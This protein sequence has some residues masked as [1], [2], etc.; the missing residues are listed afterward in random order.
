MWLMEG[1][2]PDDKTICN[3]RKD[4][5]KP[6]KETFREFSRMCQELKLYGGE[7]IAQDSVK[8]RANNSL[9]NIHNGTTVKNALSRIDKRIGE[10]FKMLEEGDREEEGEEKPGR[11]QIRAALERLKERKDAYEE[12]KKQLEGESEVS[13]VD[14][15]ARLMRS[16][17]EGRKLDVCYNVQTV[18]D[19]KH[20]LVVDYEVTDCPNDTGSLKGMAGRAME[21]MGVKEVTV[22]ADAG[23]YSSEDIAACEGGGVTCLVP[24]PAAGGP[25][26]EEGFNRKDFHYDRER[27][28]YIC[29]CQKELKHKYNKKH[30]SG[31]EYRVYSN[32]SACRACQKK[33]KCT[34]YRN[35]EVLRLT[36]QDLL[37]IV[38]E[39]TRKNKELYRK[40]KDIVEHIF[41]TVK[42]V[43]G[44]RQYLCRTK[45]K[46]SGEMALTYMA[47]N[48]RRIFNI[49]KE[50]MSRLIT[51]SG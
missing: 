28:V 30:V 24:K 27:D 31:R 47:Y 6:L 17:G 38:D 22:L 41:G 29:P 21:V 37:D 11:E 15:E 42:A 46:V 18:V 36:C 51:V 8:V 50:N 32:Y 9:D 40:R 3:F 4:N 25:K 35:R 39:R 10:Y 14:P 16:G 26:K 45:V 48:L 7:I 20:H 12:L 44:Y 1:L 34:S 2:R 13:T 19:S 43:W 49:Y 33:A 5:A 23:Y